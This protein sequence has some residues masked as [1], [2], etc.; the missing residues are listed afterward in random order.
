MAS[1]ATAIRLRN[2]RNLLLRAF[3]RTPLLLYRTPLRYLLGHWYLVVKHR[4]RRT[5]K[6]YSTVLDIQHID[7]ATGEIYV[8][9]GWGQDADWWR[10]I[11]AS[12]AVEV[13]IGRRRFVPAQRFLEPTEAYTIRRR[14]WR[15][16]PIMSRISL[17]TTNY[18]SPKIDKDLRRWAL[19]MPFVAFRPADEAEQR[20]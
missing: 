16:H 9:S 11:K 2:P 18:P 15:K 7:K 6:D 1:S 13:T 8:S 4:G 3:L 12:P 10:N 14:V 20:A 5:G 17:F 19:D